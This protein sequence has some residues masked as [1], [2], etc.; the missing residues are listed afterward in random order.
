MATGL[1]FGSRRGEHS[2]G[3]SLVASVRTAFRLGV[4]YCARNLTPLADNFD[5]LLIAI[6]TYANARHS[7]GFPRIVAIKGDGQTKYDHDNDGDSQ[8]LGACSANIRRTNVAT[9]LKITYL[10]DEYMDVKVQ[11]KA[12]DDWT[13]CFR[14]DKF[15]LPHAPFLGFS[16]L[17]GAVTDA[18]E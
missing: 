1:R 5:G 9:K 15:S 13:D 12:W 17:T 16:A 11:H 10:K 18:H 14:L 8:A 6:D 3:P 4:P 7:Y 2:P